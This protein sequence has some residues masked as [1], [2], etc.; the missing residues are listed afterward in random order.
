MVAYSSSQ[1]FD[2]ALQ[3]KR[4]FIDHHVRGEVARSKLDRLSGAVLY[5]MNNWDIEF[6]VEVTFTG[7]PSDGSEWNCLQALLVHSKLL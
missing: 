2:I 1:S 4:E 6:Q 3:C 5:R 7:S